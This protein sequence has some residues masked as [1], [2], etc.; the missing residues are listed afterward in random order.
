MIRMSNRLVPLP[1]K[2]H[3]ILPKRRAVPPLSGAPPKNHDVAAVL[4]T[5]ALL[6]AAWPY[7]HVIFLMAAIWFLG[8]GWFW[9]CRNHP[10]VAWFTL[11]F[12]RGLLGG[13]RRRS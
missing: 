12:I 7:R 10:L 1:T 9:L 11:G 4:F 3:V 5:L 6:G 2:P 8:R 13:G